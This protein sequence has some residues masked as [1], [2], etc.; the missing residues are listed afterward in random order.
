MKKFLVFGLALLLLGSALFADDAKV[1]P[2]K[3]GRLYVAPTFTL[4]LGSYDS[5]GTY[6][7]FSDPVKAF[8][9]GFALEYG[10]I[11]WLTAAV[12]WGPGWTIWSDVKPAVPSALTIFGGDLNTNGVADLFVGA[13]IQIIGEKAPLKST[14]FRFAAAPGVAIPL[15]GPDFNAEFFD[16]VMTGKEATVSSMDRHVIAMGGRFY[17]DWIINKNFFLNL[18]NETMFYPVAQDLNKDSPTLAGLKA[19]LINGGFGALSADIMALNGEVDYKYKLTFEIEP[20][21]TT[22]LANNS[23]QFSA[24]LPVNYVLT[25]AYSYSLSE[26]SP[27]L[28][29][30]LLANSLPDDAAGL[31]A[32]AGLVGKPTHAL[33]IKPNVSIFLLKTPLPLEFK[34]QYQIPLYGIDSMARHNMTLQVKAYFQIP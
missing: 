8:N 34:F 16:N 15:P 2:M 19:G 1:M 27:T 25:P 13:K 29:G 7:A 17:L 32:Y 11:N 4:G 33:S 12:Q 21:F 31:M 30:A 3:V 23:I 26:P 9:L 10:I 6:T 22:M 5:D 28:A 14:G 20:Q 18:Y 24:G